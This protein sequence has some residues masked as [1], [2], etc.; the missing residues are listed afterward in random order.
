MITHKQLRRIK[1]LRNNQT[2]EENKLWYV[3]LRNYPFKIRR[4][5]PIGNYIVDFYCKETKL[6]IEVDGIH[7]QMEKQSKY[8]SER[9]TFL[10]KLGYRVLRFGNLDVNKYFDEVCYYI[11][12]VM[13]ERLDELSN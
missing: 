4:Q 7:H 12:L 3:Y 6:V 1:E 11:D 9:T 5:H 13:N 10:E 2:F 8:D